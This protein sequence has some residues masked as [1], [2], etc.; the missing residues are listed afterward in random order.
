[1]NV[2]RTAHVQGLKERIRRSEYRVDPAAVASAL[3]HRLALV[4]LSG[5][6]DRLYP[7][8]N[9]MSTPAQPTC[10]KPARGTWLPS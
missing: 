10:S 2:D 9:G 1:M 5:A 7:G 3:L 4:D 8:A 6:E